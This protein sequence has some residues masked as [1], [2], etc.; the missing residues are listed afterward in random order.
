MSASLLAEIFDSYRLP[1]FREI[2]SGSA[3]IRKK[4]RIRRARP[5][6]SSLVEHEPQGDGAPSLEPR[7]SA[8]ARACAPCRR[9]TTPAAARAAEVSA[10]AARRRA[11]ASRA[12]R[13]LLR[14]QSCWRIEA[15]VRGTERCPDRGGLDGRV[16]ARGG[17]PRARAGA[18]SACADAVGEAISAMLCG[19]DGNPRTKEKLGGPIVP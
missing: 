12:G 3:I 9:G 11:R 18:T 13:G 5:G 10:E 19:A 14:A 1:N 7:V 8:R 4:A 16:H 15:R 6:V 17:R 2:G